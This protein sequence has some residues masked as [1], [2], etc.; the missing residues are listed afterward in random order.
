MLF[1]RTVMNFVV[2]GAL[3]GVLSVTILGPRFIQWDNTVGGGNNAMCICSEKARQGADTIIGYQ[4]NGLAIGAA[5]GLIG[6]IAW[7]VVRRKKLA[8]AAAAG[9]GVGSSTTTTPAKP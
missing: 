9:A 2:A 3:V 5:V 7:F 6:G 8:A 4:M 1:L